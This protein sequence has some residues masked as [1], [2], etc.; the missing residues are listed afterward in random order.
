MALTNV[1]SLLFSFLLLVCT[2][3]EPRAASGWHQM[4]MLGSDLEL[5]NDTIEETCDDD[6]LDPDIFLHLLDDDLAPIASR[7]MTRVRPQEMPQ[8]DRNSEEDVKDP[9]RPRKK[10]KGAKTTVTKRRW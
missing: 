4:F 10:T 8:E 3:K 9:V 7:S 2:A 6:V 5:N 1:M